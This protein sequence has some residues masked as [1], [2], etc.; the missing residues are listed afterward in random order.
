MSSPSTSR[1]LLAAA[2][3]SKSVPYASKTHAF[4]PGKGPSVMWLTSRVDIGD[5]R[6]RSCATGKL[7]LPSLQFAEPTCRSVIERPVIGVLSDRGLRCERR[8]K[9]WPG[10]FAQMRQYPCVAAPKVGVEPLV[11]ARDPQPI[12]WQHGNT[13]GVVDEISGSRLQIRN[14]AGS[15]PGFGP[16]IWTTVG[17]TVDGVVHTWIFE[18]CAQ[19]IVFDVIERVGLPLDGHAFRPPRTYVSFRIEQTLAFDVAN[20]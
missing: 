11:D 4:T 10:I 8:G 16:Q 17:C 5:C 15:G 12:T 2:A 3:K 18:P 6:P 13:A 7:F 1:H 9:R 14:E 19:N 20:G